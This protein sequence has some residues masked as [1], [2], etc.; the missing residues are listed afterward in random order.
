MM[1]YF[2]LA[3][4]IL[5]AAI[6]WRSPGYDSRFLAAASLGLAC[7]VAVQMWWHL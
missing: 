3:A 4:L 2:V 1:G 7:V 5:G 6:S